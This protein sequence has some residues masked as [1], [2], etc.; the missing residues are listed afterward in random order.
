MNK[1]FQISKREKRRKKMKNFP[2]FLKQVKSMVIN[3]VKVM[4][5]YS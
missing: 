1:R 2:S 4:K 3:Q 5:K